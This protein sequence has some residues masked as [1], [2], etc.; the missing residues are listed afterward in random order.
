MSIYRSPFSDSGKHVIIRQIK[1]K[2]NS[3]PEK[4]FPE[5]EQFL[6]NYEKQVGRIYIVE[7]KKH[8]PPAFRTPEYTEIPRAFRGNE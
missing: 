2:S 7:K 5:I 8:I 4:Y 1:G 3:A 6:E